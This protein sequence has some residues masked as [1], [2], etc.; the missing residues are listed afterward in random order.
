M[1]PIGPASYVFLSYAREDEAA[2]QDIRSRLE[3]AGIATWFDAEDIRS[4]DW[5]A[6]IAHAM[7]HAFRVLA[8]VSR[9]AVAKRGYIHVE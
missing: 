9:A 1:D 6:R 2:V 5:E 3:A 4:G 7:R 8:F